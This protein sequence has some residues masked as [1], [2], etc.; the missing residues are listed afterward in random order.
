MGRSGDGCADNFG[1]WGRDMKEKKTIKRIK[2]SLSLV[3]L[4]RSYEIG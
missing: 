3:L 4:H 2:H 1:S